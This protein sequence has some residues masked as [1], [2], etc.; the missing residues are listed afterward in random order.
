MFDKC[1]RLLSLVV[2]NQKQHV[3]DEDVRQTAL[4]LGN[5]S[6][7]FVSVVDGTWSGKEEVTKGKRSLYVYSH[8]VL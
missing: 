8:R 2:F 1:A 3:K 7:F 4:D 6:D 5:Y